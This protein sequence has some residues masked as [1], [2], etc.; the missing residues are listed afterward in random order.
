MH[1]VVSM[2]SNSFRYFRRSIHV[3]SLVH[4]LIIVV[5]AVRASDLPD[6]EKDRAFAWDDQVG[7]VAA[8][9]A[10]YVAYSVHNAN[11]VGLPRRYSLEGTSCGT[12]WMPL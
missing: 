9:A 3:V 6:L 2:L 5:L 1:I 10:G 8:V 12:L 4:S 11:I 7:L